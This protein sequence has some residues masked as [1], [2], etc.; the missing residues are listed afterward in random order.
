[1]L[2]NVEVGFNILVYYFSLFE[3]AFVAWTGT[4]LHRVVLVIGMHYLRNVEVGFY[5]LVYYFSLFEH[6]FMAWTG[7]TIRWAV[8]V[9][10]MHYIAKY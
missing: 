4:T 3:Y 6:V 9:I 7:T 1:M 2:R 10:G 5:M 8:L